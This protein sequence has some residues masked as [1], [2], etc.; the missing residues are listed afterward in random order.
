[1]RI[2]DIVNS[3]GGI[4]VIKLTDL[5]DYL[6]DGSEKITL[7]SDPERNDLVFDPRPIFLDRYGYKFQI[8]IDNSNNEVTFFNKDEG[9]NGSFRLYNRSEEKVPKSF[10]DPSIPYVYHGLEGECPPFDV[11]HVKIHEDVKVIKEGAFTDCSSLEAIFIP[12][13][14]TEIEILAFSNCCNLKLLNLPENI[15]LEKVDK[16]II[17][18]CDALRAASPQL[19]LKERLKWLTTRYDTYPFRE[20]LCNPN[21][22]IKDIQSYIE[23]NGSDCFQKTDNYTFFGG[24]GMNITPLHLICLLANATDDTDKA[25]KMIEYIYEQHKDAAFTHDINNR[26]P[27]S[28][29]VIGAKFP[30]DDIHTKLVFAKNDKGEYAATLRNNNNETA[31]DIAIKQHLIVPKDVR[32]YLYSLSPIAINKD[33]ENAEV[34]HETINEYITLFQ[35]KLTGNLGDIHEAERHGFARHLIVCL[36]EE[37]D[38]KLIDRWVKFFK[39]KCSIEK[40]KIISEWKGRDGRRVL[41]YASPSI[42]NAINERTS[43]L[44]RYE[45]VKGPVQHKSDTAI[46]VQAWDLKSEEYYNDRYNKFLRESET[47]DESAK[48]QG[49]SESNFETLMQEIA[50]GELEKGALKQEFLQYDQSGDKRIQR[51]EFARLCRDYFDHG[52]SRSVALKFMTNKEQFDKEKES[53]NELKEIK[54][55]ASVVVD[56]EDDKDKISK[57]EFSKVLQAIGDNNNS[58]KEKKDD[59]H[60]CYS[61]VLI[62]P[63]GERNLDFIYRFEQPDTNTVCGYSKAVANALD[64]LHNKGGIC[65]GDLAMCNI[66][67]FGGDLKLI[68]LDASAN[69]NFSPENKSLEQELEAKYYV[70]SKFS[71]G[72]IPPEMIARLDETGYDAFEEYFAD[73]KKKESNYWEKIKPMIDDDQQ[74]AYAVKTFRVSRHV[75][76]KPGLGGRKIP[77]KVMIVKE[78]L[79]YKPVYAS[80]AI[81]LW[82]LGVLLY[83]LVTGKP[84]FDIDRNDDLKSEKAFKELYWWSDKHKEKKIQNIKD[85]TARELLM[86][87]LS[88]EPAD[89]GTMMEVLNDDFF[90]DIGKHKT[91]IDRLE[92]LKEDIAYIKKNIVEIKHSIESSSQKI[93]KAVFEATE[94]K[95]PISFFILPWEED[96][97]GIISK[98]NGQATKANEFFNKIEDVASCI[99]NPTEENLNTALSHFAKSKTK[100][101]SLYLIDEYMQDKAGKPYKIKLS[102]RKIYKDFIPIM[103]SGLSVLST[104]NKVT[105]IAKTIASFIFAPAAHFIPTMKEEKIQK[106]R[107][108][109]GK[110]KSGGDD[111]KLVADVAKTGEKNNLRGAKLRIFEDYLKKIEDEQRLNYCDLNRYH[112]KEGNAIWMTEDSYKKMEHDND[113]RNDLIAQQKDEHIM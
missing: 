51:D 99:F 68:D 77:D 40:L 17:E 75:A 42:K 79:P 74:V 14:V 95:V 54:D 65:H 100:T 108:G 113:G 48:D 86:K 9:W 10:E 22:T 24:T 49:L 23:Q 83:A 46:V 58:S 25:S 85:A 90:L 12:P 101:Y 76:S 61:M 7:P 32:V 91:P 64:K 92:N 70:G 88:K 105:G 19:V 62:M 104:A 69:I 60:D 11:A 78:G 107:D 1:M 3:K 41:E 27:I 16:N 50:G 72:I 94:V 110:L 29:A 39:S 35:N 66:M 106:L 109:I 82:S 81:D 8:N 13:T 103:I 97:Q 56:V 26:L 28:Y 4:K 21:V 59:K 84:L 30:L 57:E 33:N 47:G 5:N 98:I 63:F 31:T 38:S 53:R 112:D 18:G 67:R 34:L 43:F 37:E 36:N 73:E 55:F 89:R 80:E 71:S 20:L 6:K 93:M 45:I 44:G 15:D 87:L 52:Q 2:I 102:E 96:D 111:S